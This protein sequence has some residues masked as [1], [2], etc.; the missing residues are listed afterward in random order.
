MATTL[1]FGFIKPQTGD[2]GSTWFPALEANIQQLNDHTH[3]GVTSSKLTANSVESLEQVVTNAGWS[4]V[5]TGTYRQLISLPGSLQFDQQMIRFILNTAPYI[6]H[7]IYPSIER[8]TANSYYIYI[9]DNS[10][11]LRILYK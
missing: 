7:E 5:T 8:V 3:D 11:G 6:G 2:K 10:L 4:L 1:S 9:N